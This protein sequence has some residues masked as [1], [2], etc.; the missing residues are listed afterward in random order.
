MDREMEMMTALREG[1]RGLGVKCHP[2]CPCYKRGGA[3]H[4]NSGL[5]P[6]KEEAGLFC[7]SYPRG[8]LLTAGPREEAGLLIA[9]PHE[10]GP[11]WP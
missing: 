4:W 1:P 8:R 2:L 3:N 10:L 9:A 5:C 6:L 7:C 11:G